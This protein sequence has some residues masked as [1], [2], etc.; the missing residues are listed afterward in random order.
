MWIGPEK[1]EDALVAQHEKQ[2]GEAMLIEHEEQEDATVAQ[3]EG[4][5][6]EAILIEH[7]KQEGA[8]VAQHEKQPGDG[9]NDWEPNGIGT[10]RHHMFFTTASKFS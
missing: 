4:Q 1:Q 3:H 7:E 9:G 2:P 5:P 6:G 8:I 10:L